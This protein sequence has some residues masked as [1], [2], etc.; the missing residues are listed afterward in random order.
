MTHSCQ[1][2]R[3]RRLRRS[4]RC[5][6]FDQ[7]DFLAQHAQSQ[8]PIIQLLTSAPL[9]LVTLLRRHLRGLPRH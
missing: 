4:F 2:R 6:E 3:L 1:G 7:P 8:P 9:R 5:A